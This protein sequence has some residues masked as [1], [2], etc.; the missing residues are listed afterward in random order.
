MFA[1]V[2]IVTDVPHGA[3]YVGV[4][5]DLVRRIAQHRAGEI[6]GFTKRYGLKRLVHFEAHEDINEAI[7]R[8][9]RFKKW[10]RA[11][12][13]R[14]IAQDNPSWRDLYGELFG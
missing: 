4:T 13:V 1:A 8:E 7:K 3:L 2:Y 9:K 14:L 12:K 6:D 11:W 5:T 10:P